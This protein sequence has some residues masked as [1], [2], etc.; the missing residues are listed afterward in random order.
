VLL[1]FPHQIAAGGAAPSR[2]RRRRGRRRSS[3]P[4]E[5]GGRVT[6]GEEELWAVR[7]VRRVPHLQPAGAD[8]RSP[9]CLPVRNHL[10]KSVIER[11]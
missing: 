8:P 3:V 1:C 7:R 2:W 10:I 5:G 11:F 4:V 9:R 6:L